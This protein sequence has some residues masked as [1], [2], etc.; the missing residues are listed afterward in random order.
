MR[1][2]K[3]LVD[4]LRKVNL[5]HAI[6]DKT[7]A[8]KMDQKKSIPLPED[9][10][11]W[12]KVG[13]QEGDRIVGFERDSTINLNHEIST[14]GLEAPVANDKYNIAKFPYTRSGLIFNNFVNSIGE[15]GCLNTIGLGN[16]GAGYFRVNERDREIQLSSDLAADTV[17]Y[18]EYRTN[19]IS[20]KT[21]SSVPEVMAKLGEEYISWQEARRKFGDAASETMA[22]KISYHQEYDEVISRMDPITTASLQGIRARGF[23]VNKLIY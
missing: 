9:Y 14:D 7:I 8:L 23:D 22:R 16:N 10:I 12:S 13:F 17:I 19:G 2:M 4:F 1:Y 20:L 6:F 11:T 15:L 5:T 3:H 18:L 21:M